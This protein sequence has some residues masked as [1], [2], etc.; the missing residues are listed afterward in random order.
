MQALGAVRWTAEQAYEQLAPAVR[1]YFRGRGARDADDLTGDVFVSVTRGVGSGRDGARLRSRMNEIQMV[2]HE[3]PVNARRVDMRAAPINALW[4]WGFGRLDAAPG[5]L[6]AAG[7]WL[8]L[9]DDLWLRAFWQVHGGAERPLATAGAIEVDALIAMTQP[10]TT[11]AAEAL[12][13][14]ESSLFAPLRRSLQ[15]GAL[16]SVHLHDGVRVH[17]VD[18]GSRWR[19]W[20]RPATPAEL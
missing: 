12:A 10:P 7:R 14:V 19:F 8:L 1:G 4:L 16:Q 3:H 13:E 9:T 18:R 5:R 15:D 6:D 17:V 11:G 20:R 2:L